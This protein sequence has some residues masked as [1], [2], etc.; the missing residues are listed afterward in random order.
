MIACSFVEPLHSC[1]TRCVCVGWLRQGGVYVNWNKKVKDASP[2]AKDPSVQARLW[3]ES[4]KIVNLKGAGSGASK[5]AWAGAGAAA[6]S[7][8]AALSTGEGKGAGFGAT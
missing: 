5:G 2:E 7:E 4:E 3:A 1:L 6:G 8:T